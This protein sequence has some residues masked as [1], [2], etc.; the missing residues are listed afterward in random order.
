M[1]LEAKRSR[2]IL[3]LSVK[4][5]WME[6]SEDVVEVDIG[7]EEDLTEDTEGMAE[8]EDS[9]GGGVEG[10]SLRRHD[11]DELEDFCTSGALP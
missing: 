10:L 8:V 1:A 11:H 6:A 5:A 7:V 4:G 3:R 2:R 9:V